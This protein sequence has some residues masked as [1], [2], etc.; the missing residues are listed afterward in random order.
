LVGDMSLLGPQASTVDELDCY[1]TTEWKALEV[2]PG[3]INK[4][5]VHHPSTS[6]SV[7]PMDSEQNVCR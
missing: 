3:M 6:S 5:E 1:S 2:K 4:W 7:T